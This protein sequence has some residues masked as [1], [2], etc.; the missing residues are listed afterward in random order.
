MLLMFVKVRKI[1]L[2]LGCPNYCEGWTCVDIHP[3]DNVVEKGDAISFLWNLPNNYVDEIKA[4][5][6]IEHLP[7]VASFFTVSFDALI[8]GG[9]LTVIT[10]NAEFFPFYIPIIHRLGFAAHV[11]ENYSPKIMNDT[12]HYAVFTKLHLKHFADNAHFGLDGVQRVKYGARL[13]A[14]MHK[15]VSR[16]E[17]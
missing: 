5:N 17:S 14:I 15:P 4:E 16:I 7:D 8:P 13:K 3:K 6:L 9:K 2:N 1:R 12:K 11:S 10:D